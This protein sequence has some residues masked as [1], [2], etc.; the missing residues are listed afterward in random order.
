MADAG[1]ESTAVPA[2]ASAA[3]FMNDLLIMIVKC[4]IVSSMRR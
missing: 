3:V 4:L 1:E 2:A